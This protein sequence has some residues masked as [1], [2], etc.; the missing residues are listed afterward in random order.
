MTNR[1]PVILDVDTGIDDGLALLLAAATPGVELVAVTCVAGNVPARQVAD[2]TRA[3]LELAGRPDVPVALGRETPLRKRLETAEETHGPRGLGYAELPAATRP[4]DPRPAA[5]LIVQV[6]RDRPGEVTLVTL[7]PLT[8]LAVA[9]EREPRL[10]VLL[11]GWTLMGG[12]YGV[13]GNT[14]PTAEWNVYVDPDAAQA[15]FA[16]WGAA[17]SP[18]TS[19]LEASVALPLAMGLD[20]TERARFLPE[21]LRRLAVLA[22]ASPPDAEALSR[23]PTTAVGTVAERP[24][25]RFVADALRFYFEFHAAADGF[26]GAALHD[27]FAVAA[28]LDRSLVRTKALFVEVETGSGP[29]SAMTVADW[30]GLT[31]RPPNLEVAVD[32]DADV[33]LRI[34]IER[35]A[36][37]AADGAGVAR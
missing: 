3:V 4:L 5:E 24:V 21:H 1:V 34:L 19:R 32:G 35:L 14:T 23:E 36:R 26:Y 6:A 11:A 22:G 7:G 13:P 12:A 8:N 15:A 9:L 30:R 25:L 37:L 16:A 10:P 31:K 28:T 20:V 29:A 33:F 27:P 2:N 17:A 18:A